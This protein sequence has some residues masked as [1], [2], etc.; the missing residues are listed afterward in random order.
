[1]SAEIILTEWRWPRLVLYFT[2]LSNDIFG[3]LAICIVYLLWGKKGS[4]KWE[5]GVLRCKLQE[6]SWLDKKSTWGGL[7]IS[8]HAIIYRAVDLWPEER[9]IPH[10][11][12]YHEHVHVEQ[13]ES[14]NLLSSISAVILAVMLAIVSNP[15]VAIVVSVLWASLMGHLATGLVHKLTAICRGE[16]HYWGSTHEES[17]RALEQN[18]KV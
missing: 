10:P 2:S 15:T 1:M 3:W 14:A 7:T 11:V 9:E 18:P 8:A 13:G 6:G 12:Q 16:D 5:A 4:L 17:A